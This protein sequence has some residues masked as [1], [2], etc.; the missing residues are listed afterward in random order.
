MKN[1]KCDC[2]ICNKLTVEELS[3]IDIPLRMKLHDIIEEEREKVRTQFIKLKKHLTAKTD[4]NY[5][6]W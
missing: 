2:G 4:T 6:K 3:E 1:K 5:S